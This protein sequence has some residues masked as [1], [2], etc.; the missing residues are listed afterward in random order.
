MLPPSLK[1]GFG[2]LIDPLVRL[3]V[4]RRVAPSAITVTGL[5]LVCGACLFLILTHRIAAF[6]VLVTLA[7]LCDAVDGPVAR[8]GGRVTKSGA[9]LDAMCDRYAEIVVIFS[10]AVVTG[11]WAL[12]LLAAA[13]SLLVSYAKARTA[14][15]VPV[16]NT[17]WP[18]LMERPERDV[19]Y[20]AGLLAGQLVPWR[21]SGH[22][23]FWWTLI[24]F[25]VL[26]H[27]TVLQRMGR[28][29][30]LIQLRG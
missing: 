11:Y 29:R 30:R 8:A 17:E 23:L 25:N 24:V 15:E 26:V 9:Y 7:T 28:A 19:L 3:L 10:V 14:L 27:V 18:D 16:S 4:A 13:G 5:L 12:S 21:P 6:C 20:V 22:D 1:S 2:R